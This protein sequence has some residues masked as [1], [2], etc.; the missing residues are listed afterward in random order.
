MSLSSVLMG[1]LVL[2]PPHSVRV[3]AAWS[4]GNQDLHV[5]EVGAFGPAPN[6]QGKAVELITNGQRFD[7]SCQC[8]ETSIVTSKQ[9]GS[10]SF[11]AD[12]H[13][14]VLGRWLS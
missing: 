14:E 4:P 2:G 6:L 11:R 12:E 1:S 5:Q 3:R 7:Q 8:H 10:E 13:T 9:E